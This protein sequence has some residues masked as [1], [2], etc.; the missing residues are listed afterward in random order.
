M[1]IGD[2]RDGSFVVARENA[3]DPA[4]I[5]RLETHPVADTEIEH[6]GMGSH[7]LEET[8]ALDNRVVEV[9]EFSLTQPVDIDLCHLIT[10]RN[11]AARVT[12]RCSDGERED[13]GCTYKFTLQRK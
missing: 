1:I 13:I 11:G 6:A 4:M 7:L 10:E 3:L 2:D 9:N 12:R 5:A 8:Q